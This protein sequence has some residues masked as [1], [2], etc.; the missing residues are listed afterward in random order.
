MKNL[1]PLFSLA[2]AALAFSGL[3]QAQAP[4]PEASET[5]VVTGQRT[6]EAVR[7]FVD[8]IA[9]SMRGGDQLARWDRRICPGVAGLRARYAQFVI[10]RMAQRVFDVGLDIGEPGCRANVL[11]VVSMDPDG[12]AEEL[13][14]DH[15]DALGYYDERGRRT[16]GREALRAFVASDA[17]VRWW[18]VSRTITQSGEMIGDTSDGSPPV[19]FTLGN[20]SRLRRSTHQDFG[21]AFI[22]VDAQ[23]ITDIDLDFA[24]LA[25]YLAMVTLAQVDPA[26]NTQDLPT[27]LNLFAQADAPHE[28][29]DWDIA[30]LRGLYVADAEHSGRRQQGDIERTMNQQL[31]PQ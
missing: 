30:Y 29:T 19:D 25:D 6:E 23:R 21:A 20:A 11:I 31:P 24:A 22:I 26:A 16:L 28:L 8:E 5:V 3:A 12:V 27:I 2:L 17:P 9:V 14:D 10:D 4:A 7:T 1:I 18:H 13:F 15:R